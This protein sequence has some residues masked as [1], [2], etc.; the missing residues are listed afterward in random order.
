MLF[1]SFCAQR[2]RLSLASMPREL[3][4]FFSALLD[5]L[6]R[7]RSR[8]VQSSASERCELGVQSHAACPSRMGCP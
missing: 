8:R 1:L 7:T 6:P 4:G 2:V 3:Q 5:S